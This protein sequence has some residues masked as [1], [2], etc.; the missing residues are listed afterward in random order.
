MKKVYRCHDCQTTA[1]L[2]DIPNDRSFRH[3]VGWVHQERVDGTFYWLCDDC[4]AAKE[5]KHD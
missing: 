5:A 1:E 2:T 4:V 3:P